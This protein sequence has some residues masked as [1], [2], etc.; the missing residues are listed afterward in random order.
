MRNCQT[1]GHRWGYAVCLSHLANIAA[2][3]GDECTAVAQLQESLDIL[4][5]IGQ[6]PSAKR[7][8]KQL[9]ELRKMTRIDGQSAAH[10]LGN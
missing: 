10:D 4:H 5:E 7:V 8:S 6:I 1:L 3:E 9:A 2:R